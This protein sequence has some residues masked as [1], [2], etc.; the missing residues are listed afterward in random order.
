MKN[1]LSALKKLLKMKKFGVFLFM[2]SFLVPEIFMILY[3]ANYVTND[4]K[5]FDSNWFKNTKSVM[6]L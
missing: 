6:P 5:S 3:Y 2:I 1:K 4:V